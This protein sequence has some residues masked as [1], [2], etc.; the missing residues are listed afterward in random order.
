MRIWQI[1]GPFP[2]DNNTFQRRFIM[3]KIKV[4]TLVVIFVFLILTF[5]H[6]AFAGTMYA[7]D[8][9]T[10]SLY[11]INTTTGAAT[12]VGPT[13]S[14]IISYSGLA[15]DTLNS[16]MYVSDAWDGVHEGLG[17][18]N[19]TTGAVTYIG[20]HVISNNIHG[21]AFVASN[22][23]MYG[24]DHNNNSLDTI[25]LAT[26]AATIVGPFGF[27]IQNARCLAYDAGTDTL[28]GI[29]ETN[30]YAI[31]RTT[32]TASLV[33][34][35]GITIEGGYYVGCEVDSET[36]VL[37]AGDNYTGNLYRI[38]KAN[39]TATLVGATGIQISGLAFV[40]E[41]TPNQL[42]VN[43]ISY[44]NNK[45][46]S[47]TVWNN[48]GTLYAEYQ[49]IAPWCL[50]QTHLDLDTSISGIPQTKGNPVPGKFEYQKRH[51]CVTDYTYEIPSG[52]DPATYLYIA[53]Q[54]DVK[55]STSITTQ[56]A[57][58]WSETCKFSGKN[59]ASC[60][61]YTTRP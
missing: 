15:Y 2:L 27:N 38:N 25:N 50:V 35:H 9:Y 48:E 59:W 29:S 23:T 54:A 32:G 43:L 11:T 7:T 40:P 60:F 12:L 55:K 6:S 49:T 45:V 56:G 57:W 26:G 42:S 13:G 14:I 3:R 10:S 61:N 8:D 4:S 44:K 1:E 24:S 41:P 51:N 30:L 34:P 46:G 33:G 47:V 28:Y 58:G 16:T 31:N 52:W 19:L 39:G 53:A 21:L 17:S 36:G 37:Y 20:S 5:G 18:V 22:N